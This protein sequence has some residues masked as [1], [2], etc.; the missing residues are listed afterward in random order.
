M[1]N[2]CKIFAKK[3]FWVLTI[4]N[5]NIIIYAQK[6]PAQFLRKIC[7]QTEKEMNWEIVLDQLKNLIGVAVAIVLGFAIG[8]ER[9][10]RAKE[11]GIRTHTIVCAGAAL[12][13]VVSKYGFGDSLEAD[14]ARIASQIVS[15]IGF[16]GAGIIVYR[17]NEI[18]GL[19]TAAGVWAT[20]GVGMAAG[21]KMYVVATGATILLIAIQCLLHAN[22]KIFRTKRYYRLKIRYTGQEDQ[23]LEIKRLFGVEHFR[24]FT[25]RNVEGRIE[26]H[27][28]LYTGKEFSSETLKQIMT[29]NPFITSI[30]RDDED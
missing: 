14:A 19:T 29:E 8:Y 13:M 20:A 30:E 10:A 22:W 9:K 7:A 6:T 23:S 12:M 11:A 24:N 16:L 27:V 5:N 3:Q 25:M 28:S 26:Y 18:H 21:A 4:E 1:R 2:S 17:K 15:G